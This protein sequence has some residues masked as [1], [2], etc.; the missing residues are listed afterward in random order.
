MISTGILEY[1]AGYFMEYIMGIKCW[2]YSKEILSSLTLT[3]M[4]V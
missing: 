4:F 1:F 3:D 2:D